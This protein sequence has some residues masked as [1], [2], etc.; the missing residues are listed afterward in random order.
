M[1]MQSLCRQQTKQM[2]IGC[3]GG[4]VV[5]SC[6]VWSATAA[7]CCC[8]DQ[9]AT[10]AVACCQGCWLYIVAGPASGLIVHPVDGKVWRQV[11]YMYRRACRSQ[12]R[13]WVTQVSDG[14]CQLCLACILPAILSQGGLVPQAPGE[15]LD[16]KH[17]RMQSRV[18]MVVAHCSCSFWPWLVRCATSVSAGVGAGM[19]KRCDTQ[20]PVVCR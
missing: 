10:P 13:I 12:I 15:W 6:H 9:Q 17:M 16:A 4:F 3:H 8:A 20:R 19:C 5:V 18:M 7:A 1:R 2:E 14:R 11:G